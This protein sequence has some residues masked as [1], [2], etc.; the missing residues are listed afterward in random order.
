M[1]MPEIDF[2]IK[3]GNNTSNRL[4]PELLKAI[5]EK[6]SDGI[7]LHG[8]NLRVKPL[9]DPIERDGQ[10]ILLFD[11]KEVA[12]FDHIEFKIMKTGWGK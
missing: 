4:V 2:I 8:Q 3:H 11:V 6:L 9:C 7:T 10:Y 12:G 1:E 5:G